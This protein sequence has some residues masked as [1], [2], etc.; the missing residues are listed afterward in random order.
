M[1]IYRVLFRKKYYMGVESMFYNSQSK[2]NLLNETKWNFSKRF[3]LII[4]LKWELHIKI[5]PGL[6]III[7]IIILY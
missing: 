6:A 3:E 5:E 2:C 7:I 1:I 4:E